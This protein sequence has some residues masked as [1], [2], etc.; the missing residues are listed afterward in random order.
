MNE[1]TQQHLSA[2]TV[3]L[4]N[5]HRGIAAFLLVFSFIIYLA[6]VAPTLSFWDCGEFIA[7]SVIMGVPHPPGSPL[8]L[9]AGHLF[10]WL[11][12]GDLGWRVN[13]ISPIVAAITVMLLYLTLVRLVR[14]YRKKEETFMDGLIVYGGAFIGAATFAFT[15]SFWFNAVEAEVY[16]AT[17]FLTAVVFYMIIRWV[18]VADDPQSDRWLLIIA[19]ML[20]LAIG[21]HL[22]NILTIP[23]IAL[24]IYFRKFKFS[25]TGFF[26]TILVTVLGFFTVYI[27]VIKWLPASAKLGILVPVL[28]VLG[29]AAGCYYTVKNHKRLATLIMVSMLL[30][31]IGNSTYGYIFIRSSLNPPIDE[32]NPDTLDRF[33]Y[34][35]NREQY[36]DIPLFTRRWNNDPNYTSESDYFFRYQI[37]Y[38]YNRYFL[39]NFVGMEGDFQGAGVKFSEFYALPLILG[40]WGIAFH[41]MRERRWAM[42]I[43]ALFFMTGHRHL[44]QPG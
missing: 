17:M 28:I 36:G 33:L 19:Y 5:M 7:C 16:G 10:S 11:P 23:V 26:L 3:S 44:R 4:K 39:W 29:I 43:F 21:V 27:G 40:L 20:G 6:T 8:Y 14:F 2:S 22:E 18:E 13:L 31:V 37:D 32:N 38:M 41:V 25:W 1:P 15:H 9:M 12:F 24:I 30:L 34:Y 35:V 42:I